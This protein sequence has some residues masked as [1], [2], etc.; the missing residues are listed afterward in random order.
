VEIRIAWQG[1][2]VALLLAFVLST[3]VA[4]VYVITHQG[5]SYSRA[6]VQTIALGGIVSALVMLAIGNDIARG[7]G[8]VGALTV[9]RFRTNVKDTRD[10]LFVFTS[11]GLGVACGVQSFGVAVI[12]TV[13]FSLAAAQLSW[14][15]FGS[16]RQF[17]AV[18]RLHLPSGEETDRACQAVMRRHCRSY[19][20]VSL[21]EVGAG[22]ALQEHAYQIK[23][24]DPRGKGDLVTALRS[25]PGMSGVTLLM[26]DTSLEA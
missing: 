1:A 16:K 17:D 9:V 2:L 3:A 8:L 13:V 15:G 10:L 22:G 7:L 23:L 4:W 11:L 6:F 14:A 26:Q 24:V 12:A 25:I 20:L 21:R 19:L 18:L 5:I